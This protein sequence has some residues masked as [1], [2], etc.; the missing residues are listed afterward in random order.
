MGGFIGMGSAECSKPQIDVRK[1]KEK[2]A[3]VGLDSELYDVIAE[4]ESLQ[5]TAQKIQQTLER[6]KKELEVIESIAMESNDPN[7]HELR[8]QLF[9]TVKMV[10][11]DLIEEML[12]DSDQIHYKSAGPQFVINNFDTTTSHISGLDVT[13]L[14]LDYEELAK[15]I[16]DEQ[17]KDNI[18]NRI[19]RFFGFRK[20]ARSKLKEK[21]TDSG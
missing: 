17:R 7:I 6:K 18:L 15:K 1:I 14:N 5:N 11:A 20:T 3:T 2:A 16:T 10:H 4:V 8:V 12:S 13:S 9:A 19:G 21:G